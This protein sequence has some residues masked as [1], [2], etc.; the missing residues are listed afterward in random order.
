MEFM[1]DNDLIVNSTLGDWMLLGRCPLNDNKYVISS[2]KQGSA[3]DA[4]RLMTALARSI[5]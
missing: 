5:D 1:K 2:I 3:R 4:L